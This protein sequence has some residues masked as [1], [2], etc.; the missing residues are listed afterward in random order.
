MRH[1]VVS[2][3][4]I[5]VA[6]LS[7]VAITILFLNGTPDAAGKSNEYSSNDWAYAVRRPADLHYT[8]DPAPTP[9]HGFEVRVANA[10]YVFADASFTDESTLSQATKS[11][12]NE[13]ADSNCKTIDTRATNLN[14][15][16]AVRMTFSC[17]SGPDLERPSIFVMLFSLGRPANRGLIRYSIQMQYPIDATP[18][19]K[20]Q[21]ENVF[22]AVRKG[23]RFLHPTS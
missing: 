2:M 12:S 13:Y 5:W 10:A 14:D 7:L 1:H 17:V 19:L 22:D 16:R 6:L 9:N 11:L 20:S 3:I 23:F 15:K 4:V 18:A 8:I 21:M